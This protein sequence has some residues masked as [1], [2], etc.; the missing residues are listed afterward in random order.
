MDFTS[1]QWKTRLP[2]A[3]LLAAMLFGV[4]GWAQEG[5]KTAVAAPSKPVVVVTNTP[6]TPVHRGALEQIKS[7]LFEPL[8][9]YS[10]RNAVRNLLDRPNRP[11]Q[12]ITPPLDEKTRQKMDQDRNWMINGMNELNSPPKPED[13]LGLPDY[14]PDGRDKNSLSPVEK[15]Y[16]SLEPGSKRA[17]NRADSISEIM[18]NLKQ[19]S[20]TN[21]FSSMGAYLPDEQDLL[22][23]N[24]LPPAADSDSSRKDSGSAQ[25]FKGVREAAA[26][27]AAE[28]EQKKRLDDFKRLMDPS[29]PPPPVAPGSLDGYKNLLTPPTAPAASGFATAPAA[30]QGALAPAPE[31]ISP[32]ANLY[33]QPAA[34]NASWNVNPNAA[35][36]LPEPP[37]PAV[38]TFGDPFQINLPKRK[39]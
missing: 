16:Q 5:D 11:F 1:A 37:K 19:L 28:R 20:G 26:S 24:L 3:M 25:N 14:G 33:A 9:P 4:H 36:N 38:N 18:W 30:Y 15:Y 39:F 7:E 13:L 12:R 27:E 34:A 29:L 22:K 17:T 31:A 23:G 2:L 32:Y 10:P 8:D 21:G 6:A 35:R